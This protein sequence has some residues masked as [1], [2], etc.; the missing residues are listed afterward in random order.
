MKRFIRLSLGILFVCVWNDISIIFGDKARRLFVLASSDNPLSSSS[1]Q[2]EDDDP[3]PQQQKREGDMDNDIEEYDVFREDRNDENYD[4]KNI[5]TTVPTLSESIQYYRKL[6]QDPTIAAARKQYWSETL[7]DIRNLTTNSFGMTPASSR[8]SNGYMSTIG[9]FSQWKLALDESIISSMFG[10]TSFNNN[11]QEEGNGIDPFNLT[12]YNVVN[13]SGTN[14]YDDYAIVQYWKRRKEQRFEGFPSWE[15]LVQ[16]WNDEIQDY[17][18]QVEKESNEGYSLSYYGRPSPTTAT[19]IATITQDQVESIGDL[20]D[21]S[22]THYIPT[23]LEEVGQATVDVSRSIGTEQGAYD[24]ASVTDRKRP[25]LPIPVPAK[26]GQAVLP[27]T[28]ISDKSKRI[29]IV[30]TAAMP[31]RTGTAVN[32]LLRA[33]Y[34]VEGRKEQG[35]SVTLMVPW[36]ERMEDQQRVYGQ[37]NLF[38]S[39]EEQTD[40][41]RNWLK[42]DAKMSS[43][44]IELNIQWYTGW[45]SKIENSIYSM[46]DITSLISST[47]IDVCILE[48]PEHLNWYRAPGES[49]TKKFPYVVGILHTNYFSYALD[50]PAALIRAPAMRLLCSWMCRA[51]CHRIIKLSGTLDKMAPEKE[52]VENVHGVR[53]TFLDAGRTV[54]RRLL[55]TSPSSSF[56]ATFSYIFSRQDEDT[57]STSASS[58]TS[59]SNKSNDPIFGDDADPKIYF[60]GKLLWSKGIGSLMELLKYAEES[61]DLKN[62]KVD[63]Y[64]GGPDMEAM[65]VRATKLELDM[66]FYGPLDHSELAFTHKIFVNPSTSEVLCT[67]S[68]E[69]LAMNKFVILPSHPSNDFFIQFPNCLTYATKEEF[70]GNLYYAMTHSPIPLND[71]YLQALSWEAATERLI[72][73]SAIP[74]TEHEQMKQFIDQKETS[75]EV[76]LRKNSLCLIAFSFVSRV[77]VGGLS[78]SFSSF[79]LIR[80]GF[81][82]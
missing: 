51:H 47:D 49:W 61:A 38:T 21:D 34:L 64:G 8:S 65:K 55:D 1:V 75:I 77:F 57:K 36:L 11:N 54:G 5:K 19:T 10:T 7:N 82:C 18:Q 81:C 15:R 56:S 48:E 35:G 69:A 12:S 39:Q 28:D 30:T 63:I 37:K 80:F 43:A 66:P 31:W 41:I 62:V 68:A 42:N 24:T 23:S 44:S 52:L 20:T 50:Q 16:D 59:T 58:S 26:P 29:L 33:A 4:S 67:T 53:E 78:L 72:M 71:E 74:V 45:Q 73:A 25:V 70:V 60:I 14:S 76:R 32:P 22:I 46:G 2:N 27:H 40:Y 79:L 17:L 9:L 13:N 6:F 3:K